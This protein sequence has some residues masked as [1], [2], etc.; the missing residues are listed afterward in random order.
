MAGIRL[1]TVDTETMKLLNSLGLVNEIYSGKNK[2]LNSR[3]DGTRAIKW[4]PKPHDLE[5]G[6]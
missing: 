3:M 5:E 4:R 6:I 1:K 2:W